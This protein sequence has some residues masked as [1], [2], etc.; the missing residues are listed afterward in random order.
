VEL[1]GAIPTE[2]ELL[3]SAF[4]VD[5]ETTKSSRNVFDLGKRSFTFALADLLAAT[6]RKR[7]ADYRTTI[8]DDDNLLQR[9]SN[10]SGAPIPSRV[11]PN[12]YR[13]AICVRKGEKEI[14]L[15][16]LQLAQQFITTR[17]NGK[18]KHGTDDEQAKKA[19]RLKK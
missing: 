4:T 12:R 13:M 14:L 9:L 18:R 5:T 16:V 19:H 10:D 7:L 8:S 2:L 15:Q 6:I 17:T 3:L 1:H 11:H